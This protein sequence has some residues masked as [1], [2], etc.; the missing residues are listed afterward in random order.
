MPHI[1]NITA[2]QHMI[3][4]RSTNQ[5]QKHKSVHNHNR[6]GPCSWKQDNCN[7]R[8]QKIICVANPGKPHQNICFE[9]PF[10]GIYL[11]PP[12]QTVVVKAAIP[13]FQALFE[14]CWK[15]NLQN[16]EPEF[17]TSVWPKHSLRLRSQM[18]GFQCQFGSQTRILKTNTLGHKF[19]LRSHNLKFRLQSAW[20]NWQ[21]K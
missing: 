17:L 9:Q 6:P 19:E 14:N 1:A 7:P 20:Q 15:N 8:A 2:T 18:L 12:S 10:L 4:N 13:A 21:G 16:S 5:A 11:T 3:L